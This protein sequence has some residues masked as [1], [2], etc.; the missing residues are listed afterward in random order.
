M[1][2]SPNTKVRTV[3]TNVLDT[4]QIGRNRRNAYYTR[5]ELVARPR[6]GL[7][8]D[9]PMNLFRQIER[10]RVKLKPFELGLY[11]VRHLEG[12]ME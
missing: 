8:L 6:C 5:S 2:Q 3:V 1:I 4:S 11:E 7:D 9:L 10:L 12:W